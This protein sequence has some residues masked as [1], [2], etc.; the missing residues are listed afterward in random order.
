VLPWKY[1]SVLLLFCGTIYF[2]DNNKEYCIAMEVH[3]IIKQRVAVNNVKLLIVAIDVQ[4]W[5]TCA[6][7]SS[8][9]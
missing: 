1:N 5:V 9:K 6:L 8:C 4:Q 7:L 2:H 3:C